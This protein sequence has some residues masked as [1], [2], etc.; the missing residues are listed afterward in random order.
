VFSFLKKQPEPNTTP[1]K[2]DIHSHLL[3]NLDDGVTSLQEA[4]EIIL[5]FA[6]MGY[7]KA[8]TTPHIMSDTYRNEPHQIREKLRELNDHLQSRNISVTVEAAAEYY[9]DEV[10]LEML[11]EGAEFLTFGSRYLLFET[12]YLTE[13][14]L[15]ND[16]IFKL[17]V[18]GYKP[19][20][21]HPERYHYMTMEKAED[22]RNRGVLL[23]VNT[24]SIIGYYSKS[25]QRLAEKLID[26]GWVDLLGS[27]CHHIKHANILAEAN[28]HK[29]Y[30]KAL[31]LPLLNNTL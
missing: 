3:S 23:Q 13:P 18:N 16:F 30:Q 27:D 7:T 11:N 12:N 21:A 17:T 26:Q 6:E 1:L 24:L 14:Y 31:A 20:L 25:V 29:Y 10:L 2:V 5:K 19:V 4:E 22:L 28:R 15:L 9:L 8:I